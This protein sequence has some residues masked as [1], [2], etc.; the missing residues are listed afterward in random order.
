L[1]TP[2]DD[3]Y[4]VI[5]VLPVTIVAIVDAAPSHFFLYFEKKIEAMEMIQIYRVCIS[6]HLPVVGQRIRGGHGG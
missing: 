4:S 6:I 1:I 2:A 5:G 3:D